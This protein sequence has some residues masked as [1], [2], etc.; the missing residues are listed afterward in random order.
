MI[1]EDYIA[2]VGVSIRDGAP[3][4]G[5][6]RYPLGSGDNPYQRP[7]DF[8]TRVNKLKAEGKSEADICKALGIIDY[9][10]KRRRLKKEG[11]TPE[12][13]EVLLYLPDENDKAN[14]TRLRAYI[15][16]EKHQE[17]NA[18]RAKAVELQEKGLSLRQ[19]AKEMG[20]TSDSSVRSLLDEDIARRKDLSMAV[21]DKLREEVDQYGMVDI[22]KGVSN[23]L[24]GVMNVDD[25]V[26]KTLNISPGKLK[27]ACYILEDE[28]YHIFGASVP[29]ATNMNQSTHLMVLTKPEYQHKDIYNYDKIHV[30]DDLVSH[31]G[32]QTLEKFI[33]PASMDPKRLMVKYAEDGGIDKDG[34]IEIRRGVKDLS[35][36]ESHYSQVRILVDGTHYIKGMAVYSDAED[37]P[38]G[39]DVVFNTNK[40]KGT[41]ILGKDKNNTVLK[42]IKKDPEDP[43]GSLIKLPSQGGQS[44][45][46]DENGDHV[47][48]DGKKQSLSLINKRADE[49][50]WSDWSNKLPSQ[51]LAKQPLYLIDRQLN[52][53]KEKTKSEFDEIC[54]IINPTVKKNLLRSFADKCDGTASSLSAASLPGQKYQVIL[55]VN[56]LKDNEIFAP[57]FDDGTLVA[58]VRYPHGGTFEI[59]K[60]YV[61][62]R[63]RE[64][65]KVIT[66]NAADA[67]GINKKVAD[68]LSGADFDGDTVMVIPLS[69]TIDVVSTPALKGLKDFDPKL[70]YGG[71]EEGTYHHMKKKSTQTEMGIISNL[72]MDMTLKGASEDE[73]ARA[74][75]HSMVVIDAEKHGLDYKQSEKDNRIKELHQKYQGHYDENGKYHEGAA[76]IITRAGAEI[77]V[78]KRVGSP[79]IDKDTGKLVYKEVEEHYIDK[80]G[81]DRI[82]TQ[83]V[84]RM[85]ITDDARDL[86][87]G[88]PGSYEKEV[89]YADYANYMKDLASQARIII[90][91]NERIKY[92]PE[93]A[94]EYSQEVNH[95]KSQLNVALMN[96]PRERQAQAIA[97]SKVK[98]KRDM[99]EEQGLSKEDYKDDLK[100]FAN[101]ALLASRYETGSKRYEITISDKEWDAI[102]SG[103]ISENTLKEILEHANPDRVKQ[104]ATPRSTNT[105]SEY[106]KAR[107][108]SLA[109]Q[110]YTNAEI[111]EAVGVSS[112]SVSNII[113]GKE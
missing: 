44:F 95:L 5:S 18:L 37:W 27:E 64:A 28:G 8:L 71:K 2:H 7:A 86:M 42:P 78:N 96:K 19:I 39:V 106:Q 59:P 25:S 11:K 107:I 82:R 101:K 36:G 66:T 68:R 10:E 90:A 85:S 61:N 9:V 17:R 87:S 104:L 47:S 32:G 12:E 13:I 94:K 110:G 79:R 35:L 1:Y 75:R 30:I 60:C 83:K 21:A 57:N 48:A 50:D 63:N 98:A 70:K 109:S 14:T 52:L 22:G 55:P 77:Q 29:Q 65:K 26:A 54:K 84:S 88:H 4:R 76:T 72:I 15:T 45:Y 56:S 105:I 93:V 58:L 6:G 41:P 46:D 97:A 113:R 31:D 62:N 81:K 108:A 69:D 99:Y 38:D 100:K 3:G 92:S 20:Y 49:G 112:S 80:N 111:A 53:A 91:K 33:Y 16:I 89:R 40:T 74:V 102:Q 23:T 73:L 67:V 43:F 34:V 51:F 24:T 103:A